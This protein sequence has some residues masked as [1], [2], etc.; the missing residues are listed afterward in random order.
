VSTADRNTGVKNVG[1]KAYVNTANENTVVR[2][3][4]EKAF[5]SMV[6]G[7]NN[8]R[9]VEAVPYVSTADRGTDVSYVT[10]KSAVLPHSAKRRV[11]LNTMDTACSAIAIRSLTNQS[12]VT[13]KPKKPLSLTLS[14]RSSLIRLGY[15]TNA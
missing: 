13:T 1:V 10:P 11:T 8:V 14:S 15:A 2:S 4:E 9:I 5:V 7:D 6:G 3:A 12:H